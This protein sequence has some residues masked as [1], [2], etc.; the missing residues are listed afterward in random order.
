LIEIDR[1]IVG[2]EIL[3][4][5]V[6]NANGTASPS[7]RP[8]SPRESPSIQPTHEPTDES[9]MNRQASDRIA[10]IL[11]SRWELPRPRRE[12]GDCCLL[13]SSRVIERGAFDRHHRV[14]PLV[15]RNWNHRNVDELVGAQTS[16]ALALGN[17]GHQPTD[18]RDRAQDQQVDP[19]CCDR[20]RR[21]HQQRKRCIARVTPPT[22]RY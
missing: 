15:R 2:I 22:T 17:N 3:D 14:K 8:R 11:W 10:R 13:D 21:Q 9:P 18:Q 4:P 5:N 20:H 12:C 7:I 19:E 16:V 6:W 1:R